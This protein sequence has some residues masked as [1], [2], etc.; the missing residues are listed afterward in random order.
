MKHII[1]LVLC[2]VWIITDKN[3]N[4]DIEEMKDLFVEKKNVKYF[5]RVVSELQHWGKV[6]ELTEWYEE[7]AEFC[8]NHKR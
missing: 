6:T 8:Y 4:M 7:F 5:D 1:Y 3:I 2:V